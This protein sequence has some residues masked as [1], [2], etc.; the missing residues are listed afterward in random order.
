[1]TYNIECM[2]HR[3]LSG[4]RRPHQSPEVPEDD[5]AVV[6]A[7]GQAM[8]TGA[9]AGT[10]GAAVALTGTSTDCMQVPV[11]ARGTQRPLQTVCGCM[12]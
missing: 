10:I 7:E 2:P 3:F 1:M 8:Q 12:D 4:T 5:K 9:P 11:G 6:G